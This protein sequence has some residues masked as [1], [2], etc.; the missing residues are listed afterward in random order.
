MTLSLPSEKAIETVLQTF[1][2]QQIADESVRQVIVILLNHTEQLTAEIT[3]LKAENQRLRDE[4]HRL[5]GEQGKPDIK[6]KRH[7]KAAPTN[8][9]SEVER[10][11]KRPH[12]KS[13]KNSH[14]KINREQVVS[15]PK[16]QLPVDAQF[17]GYEDVL[18][19][20][21]NLSTDNILFRKQKYYSASQKRT[22]IA[23]L[24][25]GY[26]G[27]FGPNLKAIAVSLYFGGNMTQGK[28]LDFFRDI[29]VSIS[30]GQ[31]SNLL[32]QGHESFHSE[33]QQVYQAGLASSPWQ[34]FDQTGTRVGGENLTCNIVC[35]PLYTVYCTTPKKDRLTVVGVLQG[36]GECGFLL[37]DV[38][39][40]LL[41]TFK[42][43]Q[44]IVSSM[45]QLPH[46]TLV[47]QAQFL[48]LLQTYLPGLGCQQ[49]TRVLEAAAI[50][51]YNNS[52]TNWPVVQTL[53]CDDAPQFKWLTDELSLCWVH[54]G[55]HYKKLNPSIA[56]HRQL[57]EV[58]L[59]EF[60]NYYRQLLAYK[61][62][63]TPETALELRCLFHQLLTTPTDYW[64]LEK[65]KH[66]TREK[67]SELLLVLEHPELPL[68]N[69]PAEL[70]ARTMVQRRQISYG[71]QTQTGTQ[72]WDTFL[73]LVA[74]TRKL[75]VSFIEYVRDRITQAGR[76][77][78]LPQMI[79]DTA[80]IELLGL[81]WR[82]IS[83]P[84]PNF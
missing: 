40:K 44:K 75:G 73:S 24:P 9:S 81:S 42:L 71:T 4:N 78:R 67:E 47:S 37:N 83:L 20:D 66:L 80:A 41:E 74:T 63:P 70:G 23:D 5:K 39:F 48:E 53:V 1:D 68:H 58:F 45:Q 84:T 51:A 13:N 30:S 21:I 22:Y 82:P 52:Q 35:N 46:D 18:I 50:A 28:L 54:E 43:P 10:K 59:T 2:P 64:E 72:A 38:A 34:H 8:H 33:K 15:I 3:A 26:T 77:E 27:Q 55:R 62:R 65:R 69:N 56:Y 31:L 57:L 32:I 25:P 19:Q 79:Q 61:Q 76:I 29:G 12:R 36:M 49:Q 16:D 17:K 60:W 11:T 6:A 7:Q 14:L